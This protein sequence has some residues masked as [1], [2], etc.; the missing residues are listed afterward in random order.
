ME[1]RSKKWWKIY[2]NNCK[3]YLNNYNSHPKRMME[4]KKYKLIAGFITM[5][6]TINRGK[7]LLKEV[8]Y[9]RVVYY[10]TLTIELCEMMWTMIRI[11]ILKQIYIIINELPE[12]LDIRYNM[13]NKIYEYK[14]YYNIES[15]KYF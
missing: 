7:Y 5:L 6:F 15:R 1:Y 8:C 3:I 13:I 11:I 10:S 9:S 14:K 4:K 12:K 2:M